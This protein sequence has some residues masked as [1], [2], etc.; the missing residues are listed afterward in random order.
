MHKINAY[1]TVKE[2][3]GFVSFVIEMHANRFI[4][5]CIFKLLQIFQNNNIHQKKTLEHGQKQE[6]K[7]Y[8]VS[9]I[10]VEKF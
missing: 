2:A 8:L 7:I 5:R 4:G 1:L 6:K 3:Y 10:N 9:N